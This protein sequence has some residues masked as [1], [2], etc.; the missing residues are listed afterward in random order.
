M[1]LGCEVIAMLRIHFAKPRE[2][3]AIGLSCLFFD[4]M[5]SMF[6]KELAIAG[7]FHVEHQLD[8]AQ[9]T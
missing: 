4:H 9:Q 8:S 1:I 2:N 6:K 5:N 3:M 7:L